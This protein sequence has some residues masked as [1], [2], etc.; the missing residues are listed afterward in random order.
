MV[1][2]HWVQELNAYALSSVLVVSV[3]VVSAVQ[4]KAMVVLSME[5]AIPAVVV[6][7]IKAGTERDAIV[8]PT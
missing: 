7:V 3:V 8:I 6:I 5:H 2:L 1:N 4:K